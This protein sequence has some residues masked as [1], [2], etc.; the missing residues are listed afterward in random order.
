MVSNIYSY[1]YHGTFERNSIPIFLR[2]RIEPEHQCSCNLRLRF[3][4]T[5]ALISEAVLSGRTSIV[6]V[7]YSV[8]RNPPQTAGSLAVT[9]TL[10]VY[11]GSRSGLHYEPALHCVATAPC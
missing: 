8:F 11:K 9:N 3:Q 6:Y 2:F 1:H 5:L 4:P 10:R 7:I